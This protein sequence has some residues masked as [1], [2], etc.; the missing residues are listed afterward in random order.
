MTE[1]FTPEE[2]A[3]IEKSLEDIKA[4]RF[5]V[6]KTTEEL[7]AELADHLNLTSEPSRSESP[8]SRRL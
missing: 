3:E 5:K 6:C 7:F 1:D 4:G 8:H 2:I